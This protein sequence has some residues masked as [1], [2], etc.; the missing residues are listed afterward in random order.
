MYG[1]GVSNLPQPAVRPRELGRRVGGLDPEA[2]ERGSCPG[3]AARPEG[4][5]RPAERQLHEG[6]GK[7]LET[8][9]F[10]FGHP[11]AHHVQLRNE[12]P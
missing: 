7:G 11:V 9:I 6:K 1:E 10:P 12:Y 5:P 4:F 3:R 2:R 8:L